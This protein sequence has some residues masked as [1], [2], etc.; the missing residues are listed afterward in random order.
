MFIIFPVAKLWGWDVRGVI[1]FLRLR[2]TSKATSAL[3]KKCASPSRTRVA[4]CVLVH[5][6]KLF[7]DLLSKYQKK[8][9]R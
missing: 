1:P 4:S 6:S 9:L 8:A 5:A 3:T 2:L 7:V